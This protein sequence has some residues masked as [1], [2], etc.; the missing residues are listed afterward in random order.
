MSFPVGT[1]YESAI[2]FDSRRRGWAA[3]LLLGVS[4]GCEPGPIAKKETPRAE[5]VAAVRNP[6]P[7]AVV[8]TARAPSKKKG[9]AIEWKAP[10]VWRTWDAG[11]A[12]AKTSGKNIFLLVYADWC[13]KCRNLAP[14]FMDPEVAKL[15]DSLVMVLLD[16]DNAPSGLAQKLGN[17]GN[18]IPRIVFLDKD[19]QPM[20]NLKA[21]NPRYPYFYTPQ[22]LM[23]L[24]G[25]MRTASTS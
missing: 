14:V 24:K 13:P 22:T 17:L 6:A 8:P 4:L 23:S 7:A 21:P 5:P 19:G 25:N 12:E 3:A 9:G 1:C 11:L 15:A 16:Q 10:F 20:P 2:M 18:Y